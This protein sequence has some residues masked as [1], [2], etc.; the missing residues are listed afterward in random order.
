M[1][2]CVNNYAIYNFINIFIICLFS[3]SKVKREISIVPHFHGVV[4]TTLS[5]D[6]T[7]EDTCKFPTTSRVPAIPFISHSITVLHGSVSN[8]LG[9]M[10]LLHIYNVA[11]TP[12]SRT[13]HCKLC[14]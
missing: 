4:M 13:R 9:I 11:V 1:L 7:E 2:V 6:M 5:I 8:G 3:H 10:F 14:Q 12:L